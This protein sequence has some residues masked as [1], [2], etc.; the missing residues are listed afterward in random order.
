MSSA[1]AQDRDPFEPNRTSRVLVEIQD[2]GR[3][4][5]PQNLD[6]LSTL[7]FPPSPMGWGMGYDLPFDRSSMAEDLGIKSDGGTTFASPCSVLWML[8]LK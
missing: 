4:I 7:S 8:Q 3:G 2:A 5:E 6:R 1:S